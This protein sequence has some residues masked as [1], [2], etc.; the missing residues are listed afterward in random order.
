MTGF[1]ILDQEV[2]IS[3]ASK[4]SFRSNCIQATMINDTIPNNASRMVV[5]TDSSWP[6]VDLKFKNSYLQVYGSHSPAIITN[7]LFYRSNILFDGSTSQ[8]TVENNHF[9]YSSLSCMIANDSAEITKN[10][11]FSSCINCTGTGY[12]SQYISI[13]KNMFT[14]KSTW[15]SE[16]TFGGTGSVFIHGN[17]TGNSFDRT[18]VSFRGTGRANHQICINENLFTNDNSKAGYL[19]FDGTGCCYI[20][21][22]IKNNRFIS[23]PVYFAGTGDYYSQVVLSHN[24]FTRSRSGGIIIQPISSAHQECTITNNTIV[25][26]GRGIDNRS[27]SRNPPQISIIN[28][29][30]WNNGTD[31]VNINQKEIRHSLYETGIEITENGNIRGD[32]HLVNINE[33]DFNLKPQSPCIN[34][35]DSTSLPDPDS[36]RADIGA[37]PF[38]T[39]MDNVEP[40][41]SDSLDNATIQDSEI[42]EQEVEVISN[43]E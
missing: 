41:M 24:I 35:G 27:T 1:T 30:I 36:T 15:K 2:I 7:N 3:G 29:I 14:S 9:E 21:A 26:N 12:D 4:P 33:L 5:I 23:V 18:T 37:V 8:R 39:R 6:V 20:K 40:A 16:L 31:L 43:I 10:S 28:S 13:T 17:I 19:S 34:K 11:F 22:N 38:E 25:G 42:E 32:P